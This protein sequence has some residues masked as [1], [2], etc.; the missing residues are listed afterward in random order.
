MFLD[1]FKLNELRVYLKLIQVLIAEGIF[2]LIQMN[3]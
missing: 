1:P 3:S 2:K